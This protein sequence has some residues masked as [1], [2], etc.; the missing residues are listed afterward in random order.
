M[1]DPIDAVAHL[2]RALER[3]D[4][5]VTGAVAHRLRENQIDQLDDRCLSIVVENILWPFQLMGQA[6][7]SLRVQILDHL[8]CRKRPG[9][10]QT[11]QCPD[12]FPLWTQDGLDRRLEQHT[13]VVQGL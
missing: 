3:F 7:Q 10:V 6:T 8:G 2:Q 4:V 11:I 12:D 13:D 9:L 1:Q 5:D